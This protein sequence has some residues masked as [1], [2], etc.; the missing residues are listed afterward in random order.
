MRQKQ[1]FAWA[2]DIAAKIL[3]YYMYATDYFDIILTSKQT[4]TIAG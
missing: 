4:K 3:P 1:S 2:A